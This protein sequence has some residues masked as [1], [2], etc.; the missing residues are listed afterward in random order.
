[1]TSNVSTYENAKGGGDPKGAPPSLR[2]LKVSLSGQVVIPY[3]GDH[4][5]M[6]TKNGKQVA[7]RELACERRRGHDLDSLRDRVRC[8]ALCT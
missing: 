2:V 5:K 8:R 7:R 1:M 6:T 4:Q 3:R